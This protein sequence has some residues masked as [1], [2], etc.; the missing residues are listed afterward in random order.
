MANNALTANEILETIKMLSNAISNSTHQGALLCDEISV[1]PDVAEA[2]TELARC[3]R[4][5]AGLVELVEV[6]ERR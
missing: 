4:M 3:L 6:E 2:A 5:V 1:R